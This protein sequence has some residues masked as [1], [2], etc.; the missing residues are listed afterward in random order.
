MEIPICKQAHIYKEAVVA[1][2]LSARAD[3]QDA[4][5]LLA[6]DPQEGYQ[7]AYRILKNYVATLEQQARNVVADADDSQRMF[8]GDNGSARVT[9]QS[10]N[11]LRATINYPRR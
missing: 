10:L 1:Q 7:Q 9:W 6:G 11:A 8:A 2:E 5:S 3:V 4:L